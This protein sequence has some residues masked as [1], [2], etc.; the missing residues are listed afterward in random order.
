MIKVERFTV[1]QKGV[2][3]YEK[4]LK[5][6]EDFLNEVGEECIIQILASSDMVGTK[7]NSWSSPP[8]LY[9]VIYRK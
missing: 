6:F 3:G 9:T 8:T 5:A 7:L 2:V 1:T 4:S